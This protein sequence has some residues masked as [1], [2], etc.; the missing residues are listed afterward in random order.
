M[1]WPVNQTMQRCE[2]RFRSSWINSLA[3]CEVSICYLSRCSLL[4][5]NRNISLRLLP[6]ETQRPTELKPIIHSHILKS[7]VFILREPEFQAN[8]WQ[9]FF[10]GLTTNITKP[11]RKQLSSDNENLKTVKIDLFSYLEAVETSCN[12]QCRIPTPY[13]W[14]AQ[15]FSPNSKKKIELGCK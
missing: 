12:I 14:A 8:A 2:A 10:L 7:T 5:G 4:S 11:D 9:W 13:F 6:M 1:F 3:C 15:F